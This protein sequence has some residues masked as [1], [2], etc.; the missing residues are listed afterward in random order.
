[1]EIEEILEGNLRVLKATSKTGQNNS[2]HRQ[3][4]R[5]KKL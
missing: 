2:K 5:Q 3:L 4:P 1:M